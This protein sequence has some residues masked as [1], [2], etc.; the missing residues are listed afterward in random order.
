MLLLAPIIECYTLDTRVSY[1]QLAAVYALEL[2]THRRVD[3]DGQVEVLPDGSNQPWYAE[4]ASFYRFFDE[5]VMDWSAAERS[6]VVTLWKA[7]LNENRAVAN[8]GVDP[9][10]E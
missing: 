4:V 3:P 8:A 9:K 6:A 10:C 7:R 1:R 5:R 2:A